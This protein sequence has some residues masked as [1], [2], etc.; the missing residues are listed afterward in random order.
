MKDAEDVARRFHE[1]YETLAPSFGWETQ[2]RSS[3]PWDELPEENRKLMVAVCRLVIPE[4]PET[5]PGQ[6][7]EFERNRWQSKVGVLLTLIKEHSEY[8]AERSRLWSRDEN[9]GAGDYQ[10]LLERAVRAVNTSPYT[11]NIDDPYADVASLTVRHTLESACAAGLVE[12]GPNA[13][14]WLTPTKE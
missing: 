13:P 7:V 9:D 14:E 1:V 8:A 6:H 4:L 3:V 12:P 11:G 2:E 10:S 5:Q